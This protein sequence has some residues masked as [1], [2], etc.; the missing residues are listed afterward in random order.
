MSS[1]QAKFERFLD[2]QQ[3]QEEHNLRRDLKGQII[4]HLVETIKQF[5]QMIE[6]E[7]WEGKTLPKL[8]QYYATLQGFLNGGDVRMFTAREAL[9][10]MIFWLNG[11]NRTTGV[12]LHVH[13]ESD[14]RFYGKASIIARTWV[15]TEQLEE[16]A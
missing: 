9:K 8:R 16:R 7:N 12:K 15:E 5:G 2:R 6:H 13:R 10:D 1:K 4:P 3:T 11:W 14:P